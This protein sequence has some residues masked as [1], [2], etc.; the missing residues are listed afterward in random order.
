M[1]ARDQE[2]NTMAEEHTKEKEE[3][4]RQSGELVEELNAAKSQLDSQLSLTQANYEKEQLENQHLTRDRD[5]L[6]AQA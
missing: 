6:A 5:S 4:Q 2:I 3:L 1:A